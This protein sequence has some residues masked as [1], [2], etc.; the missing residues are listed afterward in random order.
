[1]KDLVK[2]VYFLT[3]IFVLVFSDHRD[4]V[5][6]VFSQVPKTDPKFKNLI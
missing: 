4:Y 1:M 3:P 5:A 6:T 2:N